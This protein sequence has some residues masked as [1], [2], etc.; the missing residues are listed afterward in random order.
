MTNY[1][2]EKLLP[3]EERIHKLHRILEEHNLT[4][5]YDNERTQPGMETM[6]QLQIRSNQLMALIASENK[7]DSAEIAEMKKEFL[8]FSA[9][10][11]Y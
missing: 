3:D 2:H 7:A 1:L 10:D 11:D 4:D 9:D 5:E 8:I 6:R